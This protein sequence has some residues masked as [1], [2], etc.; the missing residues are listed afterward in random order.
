MNNK[1]APKPLFFIEKQIQK[2]LDNSRDKKFTLKVRFYNFLT[3]CHSLHLQNTMILFEC[4]AFWDSP[5][6]KFHY[7]FDI[8]V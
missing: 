3:N 1:C 7:R 8:N 2:N 6:L 4:P 5:F